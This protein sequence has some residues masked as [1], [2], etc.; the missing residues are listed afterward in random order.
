M[1][2]G[3]AMLSVA[4]WP[5]CRIVRKGKE[6]KEGKRGKRKKKRKKKRQGFTNKKT[7]REGRRKGKVLR[8]R[9]DHFVFSSCG[10]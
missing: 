5:V 2:S 6:K 3:S 9:M 10:F 1:L 7:K 4:L 8:S